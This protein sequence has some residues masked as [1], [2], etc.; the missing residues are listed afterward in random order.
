MSK[1]HRF[2]MTGVEGTTYRLADL[3]NDLTRETASYG[4]CNFDCRLNGRLDDIWKEDLLGSE[5]C[6]KV[7][8][9]KS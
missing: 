4:F 5:R 1:C 8:V 2:H 6:C 7:V 9:A 3:L